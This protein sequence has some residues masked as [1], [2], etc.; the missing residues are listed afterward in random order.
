ML[1]PEHSAWLP[2]V[3][4]VRTAGNGCV[5]WGRPAREFWDRVRRVEWRIS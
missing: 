4:S 3:A 2:A 1:C 5:G